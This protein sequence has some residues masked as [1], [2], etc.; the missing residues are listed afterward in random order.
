M[1]L[2]TTCSSV[3]GFGMTGWG[4]TL[5]RVLWPCVLCFQRPGLWPPVL[6]CTCLVLGFFLTPV[7]SLRYSMLGRESL[8]RE[9]NK[10]VYGCAWQKRYNENVMVKFNYNVDKYIEIH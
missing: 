10:C 5:W 4:G 8:Y 3:V 2:C 9:K 7:G 6:V 1:P